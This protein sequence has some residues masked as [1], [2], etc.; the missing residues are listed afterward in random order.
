MDRPS[1]AVVLHRIAKLSLYSTQ[2]RLFRADLIKVWEI[3][4]GLS[5]IIPCNVF[6]HHLVATPGHPYKIFTVIP[7]MIWAGDVF[8]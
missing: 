2:G 7:L 8:L 1:L 6:I 4:N 5:L 3:F